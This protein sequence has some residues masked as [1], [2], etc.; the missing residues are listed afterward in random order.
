MPRKRGGKGADWKFVE[1]VLACAEVRVLYLFGPPGVGKT[2]FAYNSGRVD[3]GVFPVTLTPETPASEMRGH[4]LPRG[5]ELVWHD[6]PFTLAMRAGGRLVINEIS[7]ASSD[8]LAILYPV[9]ESEKTAQLMLPTGE[10]VRP[11]R[12]F[13][14]VLTDNHAPDDLPPA[15]Q[16]RFD[17]QIHV[18]FPH[19]GALAL[20]DARLRRAAKRAFALAA[21]R[22]I[23]LRKWL[24]VNR[25]QAQ[26]GLGPACHAVFGPERGTQVHEALLLA[27]SGAAKPSGKDEK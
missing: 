24:T 3:R 12:H 5:D 15:L 20:L 7:H 21:D 1:T 4:Y 25:L 26:L 16:D 2:Y 14:V 9:L 17:C 11:E 27:E 19:P 23:S 22:R 8:V 13:H 18:E 10:V 6:G